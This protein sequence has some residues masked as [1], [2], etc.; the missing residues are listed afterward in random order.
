MKLKQ[1]FL[2][3][4]SVLINAMDFGADIFVRVST[5]Y[6]IIMNTTMM[7]AMMVVIF[8]GNQNIVAMASFLMGVTKVYIVAFILSM[9]FMFIKAYR[10]A[11]RLEE[12][13]KED[14]D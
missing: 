6:L 13:I 2:R 3:M 14:N 11:K 5:V 10:R 8:G 7:T 12:A 4:M 9:T 1:K